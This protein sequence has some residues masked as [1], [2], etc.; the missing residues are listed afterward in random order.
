MKRT[1]FFVTVW[2]AA[3]GSGL[4]AQAQSWRNWDFR[5]ENGRDASRCADL[6]VRSSGDLA[7]ATENFT[8]TKSTTPLLDVDARNHSAVWVRGSD[9][10]DY[11]VEVCKY[12]VGGSRAAADQALGSITVTRNGGHVTAAG[13]SDANVGWRVVYFVHTPKDAALN[14]ESGNSPVAAREVNGK[15]TIRSSNGPVSLSACSGTVDAET[16][17]GPISMDGGSG[18]VRLQAANGPI[19]LNLPDD[20]WNG[21]QL[22]AGTTNG[23]VSVN[24][25]SGFRTGLRI[26]S[27][28]HAPI[29]CQIDACQGARTEGQRFFPRVV[30]AG[31]G[32]VVR[33]SSH[34]G[35]VS[36]GHGGKRAR[37]I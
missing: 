16:T 37:I 26:E 17:N 32:D 5:I 22:E 30:S 24:V 23:P 3:A 28:G 9:R 11:G 10:A 20:A 12:A 25:P 36:V 8:F 29:S 6:Q 21:S 1:L 27:S 7:Q 33:I 15:L 14:V 34:N 2:A 19:A 18:S 4:P 13:P 35:P 31:S